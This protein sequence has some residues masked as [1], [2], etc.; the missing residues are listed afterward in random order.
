MSSSAFSTR[1]VAWGIVYGDVATDAGVYRRSPAGAR[2]PGTGLC[3]ENRKRCALLR[4]GC[5]IMRGRFDEAA[6]EDAFA[7]V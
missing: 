2:E 7:I 3:G 1:F 5:V 6:A 4:W